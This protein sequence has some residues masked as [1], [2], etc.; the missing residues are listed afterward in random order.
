MQEPWR[1]AGVQEWCRL[2]LASH[3][4]WTA[5]DLIAP[6]GTAEEEARALFEAPFVVVSHGLED[7]PVLNYG[8]RAA[9]DLWEM[10]WNEFIRT[11]S[12]MTAEPPDQAERARMLAQAGARGFIDDYRGG[13]V[14]AKGRRFLVDRALVWK[15]VDAGG[16]TH[17]Q[18]A[19][20]GSWTFMRDRP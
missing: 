4:H 16:R 15:V 19:T 5:R 17:G 11:P 7:D 6:A 9:L 13:R 3:R 2:L 18:A 1:D 10:S 8:N 12:R 20:F 14:S